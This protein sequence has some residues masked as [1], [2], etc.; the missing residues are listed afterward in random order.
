MIFIY[1]YLEIDEMDEIVFSISQWPNIPQRR[2][3]IQ[4]EEEDIHYHLKKRPLLLLFYELRYKA[5]KML[6]FE[7]DEKKNSPFLD[8]WCGP[9][10]K[11][12]QVASKLVSC[13]NLI[14]NCVKGFWQQL[15]ID[16]ARA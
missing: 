2:F 4:I 15:K 10:K 9:Y 6:Y 13:H 1:F 7:K 14:N 3:C 12:S 11:V 16:R 8:V 5:S